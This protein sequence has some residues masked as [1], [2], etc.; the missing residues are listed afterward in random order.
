MNKGQVFSM[1]FLLAMVLVIIFFGIIINAFETRTYTTKEKIIYDMLTQKSNS[2]FIA[3]T[4]NQYACQTDTG[5]ILPFSLDERKLTS[6]EELKE[7]IGLQDRNIFLKIGDNNKFDE[8][9]QIETNKKNVAIDRNILVCNGTI[10][11]NELENCVNGSSCNLEK[12]KVVLWV[13]E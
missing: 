9:T 7:K 3:M 1:D 4:T 6:A 11:F 5:N 10:Q 8:R 2:A 13:S 12:K